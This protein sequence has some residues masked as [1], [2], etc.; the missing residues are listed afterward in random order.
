MSE[1]STG[2]PDPAPVVDLIEAFRRS[3]AMFAAVSLGVFDRLAEGR[4]D[5][6]TLAAQIRA[7]P[8]ALERLLDACTGLG[9][10][11]KKNKTYSCTPVA[12]TYLCRSSPR[13]MTGYILYSNRQLYALWGNLE[14]AVREG[15][16]RWMQTFHMEG[17]IFAQFFKTEE[18]KREFLAGMHG[19]G[20]IS[21]PHVV[22]AYDLNRFRRLVDLGGARDIWSQ[23]R[24]HVTP[25]CEP[26]CLISRRSSTWHAS[27]SVPL[28]SVSASSF[29][30]ATSSATH[31]PRRT[32]SRWD[33]SFTTG[34]RQR[35][36]G[37]SA[38]FTIGCLVAARY[39]LRNVCLKRRKPG[40]PPP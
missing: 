30:P 15:T 40:R 38:R 18:S 12:S 4:A 27:T 31:S 14:D 37:C 39:S 32:C 11:D 35:F 7:N 20:L 24:V 34:R 28:Q 26:R 29:W 10:L 1:A 2:L 21:S 25:R 19:F 5:A 23:R 33:A 16:P 8:D 36:I 17:P 13:T 22:A 3:K 9:F 6:A